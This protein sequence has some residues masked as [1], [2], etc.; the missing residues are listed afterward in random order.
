MVNMSAVAALG[1]PTRR[2]VV[3]RLRRRPHAVGELAEALR[4]SQPAASHQLK[5]LRR[6]RLV[7]VVPEGRRRMYHLDP[8]GLRALR[9]WVESLWDDALQAYAASFDA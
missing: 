3:D 4:I 6:A 1:D 5:V 8:Q 2:R 7:R 9:A